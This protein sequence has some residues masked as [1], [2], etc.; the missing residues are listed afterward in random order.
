MRRWMTASGAAMLV[1]AGAA[2]AVEPAGEVARATPGE[3]RGV[4]VGKPADAM[5]ATQAD[6]SGF[7]T[8]DELTRFL[9]SLL[10]RRE[11]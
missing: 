3:A 7:V 9:D 5:R 1:A 11:R 10:E 8:H 2:G 4:A 6:R